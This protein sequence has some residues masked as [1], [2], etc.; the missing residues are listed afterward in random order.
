MS[1]QELAWHVPFIYIALL[2]ALVTTL[3]IYLW[4]V[5]QAGINLNHSVK[6]N[7]LIFPLSFKTSDRKKNR[8]A[9]KVCMYPILGP[10]LTTVLIAAILWSLGAPLTQAIN[11]VI[12]A[13]II[14]ACSIAIII[15]LVTGTH[16]FNR[17]AELDAFFIGDTARPWHWDFY[18]SPIN[19]QDVYGRIMTRWE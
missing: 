15:S 19:S 6:K 7:C 18:K 5:I 3:G 1:L 11:T 16:R 9:I 17:V 10:V 13:G 4:A 8:Q 2:I 14:T 12:E